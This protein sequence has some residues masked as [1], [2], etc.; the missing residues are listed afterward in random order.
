[1]HYCG[2]YS[3]VMP[4][5]PPPPRGPR[6]A[7]THESG[8][9]RGRYTQGMGTTGSPFKRSPAHTGFSRANAIANGFAWVASV[10]DDDEWMEPPVD[11]FP[12]YTAVGGR[13]LRAAVARF[14]IAADH[15]AHVPVYVAMCLLPPTKYGCIH[16]SRL[17]HLPVLSP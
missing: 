4:N 9:G 13:V 12:R 17:F 3:G 10:M 5:P 7:P 2:A 1:M 6:P 15:C 16:V 8:A 11:H 14:L